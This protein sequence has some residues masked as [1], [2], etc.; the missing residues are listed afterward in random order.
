MDGAA[1][2]VRT[3]TALQ[4]LYKTWSWL[5]WAQHH[6]T[7]SVARSLLRRRFEWC[8]LKSFHMLKNGIVYMKPKKKKLQTDHRSQKP[9]NRTECCYVVLFVDIAAA[10]KKK[11]LDFI[12]K[13]IYFRAT[14]IRRKYIFFLFF[15]FLLLIHFLL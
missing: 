15:F 12:N 7:L 6:A 5:V 1:S 9:F 10:K 8:S 3:A 13:F 14:F 4:A 11:T 2:S